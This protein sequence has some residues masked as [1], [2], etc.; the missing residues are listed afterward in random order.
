MSDRFSRTVDGDDG[1]CKEHNPGG[2]NQVMRLGRAERRHYQRGTQN[3]PFASRAEPLSK[4][5]D[6]DGHYG[7]LG[8]HPAMFESGDGPRVY[9]GYHPADQRSDG[10]AAAA[11]AS[12]S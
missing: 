5:A 12:P 7:P 6:D 1:G 3:P 11:S 2:D 9:G 4:R 8:H 10:A